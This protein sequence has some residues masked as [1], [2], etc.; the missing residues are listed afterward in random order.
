[1]KYS[2][3]LIFSL[4][5]MMT[6]AQEKTNF[7]WQGH[8]GCRGLLP[9]NSI[10]AFLHALDY[11]KVTT[12]ELDVI[13]SA[14][15]KIVVSHEAW[16]NHEIATKPNGEA[17]TEAEEKGFNLYKMP[18]AEIEK[19]DCGKRGHV[20]FKEQKLMPVVKPTLEAVVLAVNDFCKK[21][22]RP[23]PNYNIELK[24]EGEK[25]DN[26]FHPTPEVFAKAALA[27]IKKL[28]IY[29]KT[30]IQSFDVRILQKVKA[31]DSKIKLALLVENQKGLTWN[32]RKLGFVPDIYSCYFKLLTKKT[33]QKCHKKGMKVIPWTVNTTEDM[34]ALIELGVDGIITDY[35]NL[36][37]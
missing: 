18:Y 36:A 37:F 32:L 35:P 1:M 9:E 27:E 23:L 29:E 28:G 12:L 34:K 5:A 17:V 15:N 7:D 19:F 11:Q 26:V 25:G 14:D 10:P 31:M 33:V 21:N 16:M 30:N 4:I 20:R 24:T 8:R 6:T 22:N 13:M 2:A 3:I